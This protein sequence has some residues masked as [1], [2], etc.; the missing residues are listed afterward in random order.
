MLFGHPER[1]V[2]P[3]LDFWV[4]GV[5]DGLIGDRGSWLV[6][7]PLDRFGR[8]FMSLRLVLDGNGRHIEARG[9]ASIG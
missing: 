9:Y 6:S 4:D 3:L 7:V 2:G 8:L 5:F 1:E